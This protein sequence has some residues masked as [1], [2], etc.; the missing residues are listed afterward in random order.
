M[1][2]TLVLVLVA[3]LL[4]GVLIGCVGIG[5]VLLPPALVYLGGLGFHLAAATSTWAFLF[6]GAAGTLSYSGNRSIDW[7][8]ATWLGAGVVPT[9]IAGAWAN[10][11]LPEGLLMALLAALMVLTGADALLRGS[12]DREGA[13]RLGAPALFAVGAFVGFGSALT[14]TGGAV[15]LVPILLLL[16]TPV[17]ASVGAAQAVSLPIVAFSTAGYLIYGSVDFALGTA[18][19]LVGAAGVVVGARIA[20]AAPAT[21]LRRLVATVLLCAGL[22][23]AGQAAWGAT[24]GNETARPTRDQ[25][26]IHRTS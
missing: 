6:C 2:P 17:L 25:D 9:A 22:L 7:R 13:R 1:T 19:G 10:T 5:G 11:A 20:H 21:G 12:A 3:A 15:L 8:M 18:A 24:I 16:R 23:I 4:V 14:G 26:L